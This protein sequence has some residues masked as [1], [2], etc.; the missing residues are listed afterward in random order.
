[1][2]V[3]HRLPIRHRLT[4][5]FGA[6][7]AIVVAGFSVFVYTQTGSDLLATIDANLNSRADL[8]VSGVKDDG[9]AQVNVRRELIENVEVYAQIDN[10]HGWVLRSTSRIGRSRLLSPAQVR[11]LRRATLYN[12]TVPGISNVTRV[13]AMPVTTRQGRLVVA[14]GTSLQDRHDELVQ[15]AVTLTLAGSAALLLI[16]VG[17]WLALA[18]A[19]RPVEGMRRQAAAISASNPGR[20]LSVTGGKD[21]I[22]LLGATLNQMLDRIEESVDNERRLVD[23]AS[24][25]LRT[26]LAIQRID[27]DV[28]LSGPQSVKELTDALASVSQEN[29]HLTRL[30]ED[31]LVLS[32]ARKGVLPVRRAEVALPELLDDARRRRGLLNSP[33]VQVSFEAPDCMVRVDPVWFRQAVDNLVDNALRHTPAGGRVK[34][35]ADRQGDTLSVVVEDTGPGFDEAFLRQAFEPFARSTADPE[36]R[37]GPAGLGLAVVSTI[38]R[39]HGGRAWAQNRPEG[40]ARVTMMMSADSADGQP[41]SSGEQADSSAVHD[42]RYPKR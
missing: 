32:R 22:A 16:S 17:A 27:L 13:L 21:E 26:P 1:M 15:L 6:S 24:H 18:G 25:E 42:P 4:I 3:W 35:R 37:P 5:A 12:R 2:T 7:A 30:T 33:G 34:V 36:D 38:A 19:L 40:G 23:R 11:S 8:L 28:A 29:A 39:A 31:L 14:V 10:A 20:R 9:A 41:A